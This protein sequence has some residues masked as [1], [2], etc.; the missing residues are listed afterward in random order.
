MVEFAECPKCAGG[1]SITW[2]PCYDPDCCGIDDR[3]E[4]EE[5]PWKIE[6]YFEELDLEDFRRLVPKNEGDGKAEITRLRDELAKLTIKHG[7]VRHAYNTVK[8]ARDILSKKVKRLE[9]EIKAFEHKYGP[10]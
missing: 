9:S 10:L 2:S 4:C 8:E 7:E 6:G 1:L 3:I 5:C